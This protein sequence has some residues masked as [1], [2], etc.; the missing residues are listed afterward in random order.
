MCQRF[1]I[2]H[3]CGRGSK[4]CQISEDLQLCLLIVWH[5]YYW[6]EQI[7]SPFT[8]WK[9]SYF[10][11]PS[12]MMTFHCKTVMETSLLSVNQTCRGW[13]FIF[14][15]WV[16]DGLLH[17][18]SSS[19]TFR[20][21][22]LRRG[23]GSPILVKAKRKLCAFKA[24]WKVPVSVW[25]WEQLWQ[26]QWLQCAEWKKEKNPIR[27]QSDEESDDAK[28][29]TLVRLLVNNHSA[30]RSVKSAYEELKKKPAKQPIWDFKVTDETIH[31]EIK[32]IISIFSFKICSFRKLEETF[33]FYTSWPNWT[34]EIAADSSAISQPWLTTNMRRSK[35]IRDSAG[36]AAQ[37][38]VSCRTITRPWCCFQ[39][40]SS[41]T[42]C[43]VHFSVYWR[44]NWC[45][46]PSLWLDVNSLRENLPKLHYKTQGSF[47][48][49]EFQLTHQK[50]FHWPAGFSFFFFLRKTQLTSVAIETV[51]PIFKV[52]I[53][54]ENVPANN[55]KDNERNRHGGF[56][57]TF[58]I[59]HYNDT[60]LYMVPLA[61][62]GRCW[63]H[64]AP[65][66][67]LPTAW[68]MDCDWGLLFFRTH[69]TDI[70]YHIMS[71]C[72]E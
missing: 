57:I 33:F 46:R 36:A 1:D 7:V 55:T 10:T 21:C 12:L 70:G 25:M 49:S 24:I 61:R 13:I 3:S 72:W 66:A 67:I 40:P 15:T 56:K 14:I 9:C 30:V 2:T 71:R 69:A 44:G 43:L 47:Q 35:R 52:Y 60:A 68:Q 27:L 31:T 53:K 6:N 39:E 62:G 41:R 32:C 58:L 8:Q 23:H 16:L 50:L 18:S 29:N 64:P 20:G 4:T 17:C 48:S 19:S 11:T 38:W 28:K 26:A 59:R 65:S 22:Q 63:R 54:C 34:Q 37:P 51:V 45:Q 5:W 42:S